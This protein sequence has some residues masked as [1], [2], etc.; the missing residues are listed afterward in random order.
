MITKPLRPPRQKYF[1]LKSGERERDRD[2]ERENRDVQTHNRGVNNSAN[3]K[4][5]LWQQ[6][7]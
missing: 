5:F 6:F 7:S 1:G 3:Q 2:N 4:A